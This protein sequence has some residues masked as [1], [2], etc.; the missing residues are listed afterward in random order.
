MA[1]SSHALGRNRGAARARLGLARRGA[2]G[3]F[4]DA[5]V[6]GKEPVQVS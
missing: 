1:V 4:L 2:A 3:P 5:L 6:R